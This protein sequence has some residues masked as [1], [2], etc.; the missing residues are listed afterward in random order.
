MSVFIV[1]PR[2]RL[3]A[4]SLSCLP[5]SIGNMLPCCWQIFWDF[6]FA[7]SLYSQWKWTLVIHLLFDELHYAIFFVHL[8]SCESN[9]FHLPIHDDSL[10]DEFFYELHPQ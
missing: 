2:H 1:N 7:H 5:Y 8:K 3:S 9:E 4:N 10:L 6:A